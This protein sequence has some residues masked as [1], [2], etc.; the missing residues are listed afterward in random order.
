MNLIL[1]YIPISF[2][3][4]TF[5]SRYTSLSLF[6]VV[7]IFPAFLFARIF[8]II[9]LKTLVNDF[10]RT[11]WPTIVWIFSFT[12]TL[13]FL[14]TL[15]FFKCLLLFRSLTFRFRRSRFTW[16]WLS[17]F[18]HFFLYV[19]LNHLF[20]RFFFFVSLFFFFLRKKDWKY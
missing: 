5:A 13:A 11:F 17:L 12:A 10:Y 6:M 18:L 20:L 8:F 1:F 9:I 16:R 7:F 15:I 3:T 19:L 14:S 4:S 2:Q